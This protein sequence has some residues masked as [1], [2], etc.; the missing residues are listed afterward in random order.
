MDFIDSWDS[1]N[2]LSLRTHDK[3]V[4]VVFYLEDFITRRKKSVDMP[5]AK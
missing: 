2:Q 1:F 5:N 4:K 3:N